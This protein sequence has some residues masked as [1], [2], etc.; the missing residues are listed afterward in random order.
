MNIKKWLPLIGI[1]LF[2]YI[3]IKLDLM[4]V[5]KEIRNVD[6]MFIFIALIFIVIMFFI[7]TFKWFT[8]AVFQD[9]K[10]PFLEAVKITLITNFYGFITPSKLGTVVRAEYLK[11][12][13]GNI[14]KG[15]CNFTLDK[16]LDIASI[17]FLAILFSFM[18]KDKLNLPIGFFVLFFLVFVLILLFFVGKNRSKFVLRFFYKRLVPENMKC[19]AKITFDSFYDHMP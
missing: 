2:V 10:M 12:Y 7:Q 18:F 8:I 4:E 6:M 9:I 5:V 13:T 14:G 16:M 19:K 11:K 17:I 3:L 1:L 15:L